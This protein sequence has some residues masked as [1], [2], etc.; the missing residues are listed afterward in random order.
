MKSGEIK[1]FIGILVVAIILV[2]IIL[3]PTLRQ[4]SSDPTVEPTLDKATLIGKGRPIQGDPKAPYTLVM[5]GDY[6]CGQCARSEPIVAKA[7]ADYPGK[8][9]V[10]FHHLQANNTHTHSV[11]ISR[12]VEA[13]AKQGRFWEMHKAVYD[14]QAIL[15]GL[16]G[17]E[18]ADKLMDIARLLKMDTVKF[19]SDMTSAP[20]IRMADESDALA[21][22]AG[23]V[24]TPTFFIVKDGAKPVRIRGGEALQNW[25]KNPAN[26]K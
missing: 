8:L 21:R 4:P 12:G 17:P 9:N 18:L 15:K 25:M 10:I 6:E 1:L 5:F 19:R 14:Q 13:A 7:L 2:A 16:E 23:V 22:K 3:V 20:I 24:E 26:L 11:P